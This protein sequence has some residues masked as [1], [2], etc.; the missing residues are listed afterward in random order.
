VE[1]LEEVMG[2]IVA[3]TR[4]VAET[5]G[6]LD[7]ERISPAIR[8]TEVYV[9]FTSIDETLAAARIASDLAKALA[10][11]LT[12]IHFRSVPYAL[13]ID[14]PNGYSP[15]EMETFVDRLQSMGLD[16]RVRVCLCRDARQVIPSAFRRHSLIVI[17]G[18]SS[19][20]PTRSERCRRV[21]E[22]AGHFVV[23]VGDGEHKERSNA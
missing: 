2:Q 4:P 11:P 7:L 6:V 10:V 20:W 22:A 15:I 23:F 12:L 14:A 8:T 3:L 18:R 9:V 13:P 1:L 17:G 19:W 16:V 21:L 5:R